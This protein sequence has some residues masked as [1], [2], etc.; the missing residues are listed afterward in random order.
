M[1]FDFENLNPRSAA[2]VTRDLTYDHGMQRYHCCLLRG[3]EEDVVTRC[4]DI[5]RRKTRT[6]AVKNSRQNIDLGE[7]LTVTINWRFPGIDL[8]MFWINSGGEQKASRRGYSFYQR[9]V[10]RTLHHTPVGLSRKCPA[11]LTIMSC[12]HH[13]TPDTSGHHKQVLL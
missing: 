2:A 4:Y 9:P 3:Y 6:S 8:R 13:L 1:T 10:Q 5:E 12:F 11:T 7:E